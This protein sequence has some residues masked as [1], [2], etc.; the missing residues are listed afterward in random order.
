MAVEWNALVK[1]IVYV[2][3][4]VL[5]S[6]VTFGTA[7]QLL[8]HSAATNSTRCAF[9]DSIATC[10]FTI[11]AGA[12]CL[13][14]ALAVLWR[15]LLA[16]FTDAP[17]HHDDESVACALLSLGW[18]IIA[19]V[20]SSNYSLTQAAVKAN[21]RTMATVVAAFAWLSC[22]FYLGSAGLFARVRDPVIFPWNV[23]IRTCLTYLSS[24]CT[25]S[26][27]LLRPGFRQRRCLRKAA[28]QPREHS[29]GR[30]CCHRRIL[31][32]GRRRR[33]AEATSGRPADSWRDA[34]VRPDVNYGDGLTATQAAG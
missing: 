12:L 20:V 23:A 4:L 26:S 11:S 34:H 32:R 24:L 21:L 5:T 10:A 13:L 28:S 27:C 9:N 3:E 14:G 8:Y 16:A 6:V 19:C 29:S 30:T 33:Q 7:D 15:R 25:R 1:P 31:R 22:I 2:W 17:F 18:F